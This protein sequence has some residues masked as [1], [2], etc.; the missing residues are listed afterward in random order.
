MKELKA[1]YLALI[2]KTRALSAEN[3]QH[4]LFVYVGGHGATENEKQIY[5]LNDS[6]AKNAQMQIEFKLR[7]ISHDIT[8]LTQVFA[9][10][11]CCRVPLSG[12]PGLLQGRGAGTD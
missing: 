1:S 12:M 5:L 6:S 2:K 4:L 8:S 9:V 7:F 3:K 11:D 10:F